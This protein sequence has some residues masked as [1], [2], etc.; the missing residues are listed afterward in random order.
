VKRAA[1]LVTAMALLAPAAHAGQDPLC[2]ALRDFANT[3]P[4]NSA[5]TVTVKTDWG[6]EPTI[7]CVRGKDKESALLCDKLSETLSIEFMAMNVRRAMGCLLAES[8]NAAEL[9]ELATGVGSVIARLTGVKRRPL[10]LTVAYDTVQRGAELPY[11]ALTFTPLEEGELDY[12]GLVMLDAEALAEGGIGEAYEKLLPALRVHVA[13]PE[14]IE[15]VSNP[16]TPSYAIRFRQMN[17]AVYGPGV[18]AHSW[19]LATYIFFRVVNDQLA[20]A[21]VRFY[22]INTGNDLGGMFLTPEQVAAA[23]KVLKKSDWPYLPTL[24]PDWLGQPH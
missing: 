14:Q 23:R 20:Q 7:G 19:G 8:A 4:L 1:A 16:D 24:E 22:A 3:M 9:P 11:L 10:M 13:K 6:A 21:P 5:H 15:E 2:A 18:A 17:H 12:D